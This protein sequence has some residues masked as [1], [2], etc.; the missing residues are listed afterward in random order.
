MAEKQQKLESAHKKTTQDGSNFG[1]RVKEGHVL[2]DEELLKRQKR[3]FE[4]ELTNT[5][6]KLKEAEEAN[7]ADERQRLQAKLDELLS[8]PRIKLPKKK[9]K[10][11]N[12][13][14]DDVNENANHGIDLLSAAAD[15]DL[16]RDTQI[17]S[18]LNPH[19]TNQQL[20]QFLEKERQQLPPQQ[21]QLEQLQQQQQS[22]QPQPSQKPQNASLSPQEV[23]K[24]L[25]G[26]E[27]LSAADRQ[28]ITGFL[29]GNANNSNSE[30]AANSGLKTFV[31]SLEVSNGFESQI[32]FE[33]N[34]DTRTWRKLRRK[35]KIEVAGSSVNQQQ[36]E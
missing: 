1:F 29:A 13:S 24:L 8:R 20:Q 28:V 26:S 27:K 2:T 34:Y 5:R 18:M 4:R 17:S 22:Q 32:L 9:D 35:R 30:F 15:A 21:L 33:I 6:S 16:L 12:P 14:P 10:Q 36:H 7:N 25:E 31:L 3:Q 19:E 23:D 11:A